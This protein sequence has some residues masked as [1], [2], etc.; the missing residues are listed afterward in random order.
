[1][2]GFTQ[3]RQIGPALPLAV[4]NRIPCQNGGYRETAAASNC[5]AGRLIVQSTSALIAIARE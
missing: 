4:M 5:H 1:M 2:R 3:N